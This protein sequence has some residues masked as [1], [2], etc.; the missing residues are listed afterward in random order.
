MLKKPTRGHLTYETNGVK[1]M[2]LKTGPDRPVQPGTGTLSGPVLWKNRKFKKNRQKPETGGSTVKTA[3]R[4][5][6]TGFGPV[7]LIPKL[8]RFSLLF[9]DP[10]PNFS[11]SFFHLFASRSPLASLSLTPVT[12]A[13]SPFPHATLSLSITLSPSLSRWSLTLT[14]SISPSRS[15]SR[16]RSRSLLLFQGTVRWVWQLLR[17]EVEHRNGM[18]LRPEISASTSH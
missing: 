8:H 9:P 7:P 3:N 4:S 15:L 6:W 16:S 14:V 18:R 5:G 13:A 1:C 2:V 17:Q 12:H 11:L 10:N